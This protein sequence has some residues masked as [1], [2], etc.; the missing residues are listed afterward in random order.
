ML[1]FVT[2]ITLQN[3]NHVLTKFYFDIPYLVT[4]TEI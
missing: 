3:V 2:E 4:L 1:L